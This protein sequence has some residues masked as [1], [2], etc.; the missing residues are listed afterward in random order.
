MNKRIRTTILAT[1]VAGGTVLGLGAVGTVNAQVDE[2]ADVPADAP[3]DAP[4]DGEERPD[5]GRR[6]QKLNAIAQLLGMEAEDLREEI[7]GG[8]TLADVATDQGVAVDT[9]VDAIVDS[10]QERIAAAVENGRITQAE[11]DE[12]LVDLEER[13]TTRVNEGRPERGDGEGQGFGPRGPRGDR[14]DRGPQAEAPAD[15]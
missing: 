15:A 14:G 3:A 13:V 11:A 4:A 12:K 8:A 9:V 6:G 5:R 2:P 1:A 7:R 10:K